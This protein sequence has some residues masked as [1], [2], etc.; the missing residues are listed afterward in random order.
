MRQ[1]RKRVGLVHKLR[2]RRRAEEVADGRNDGPDVDERLRR[3]RLD[4]LRGH[5]L[6]DDFVHARKADAELVEQQ[7]ADR[8]QAAVA[9]VVDVVGLADAVREREQIVDR[10]EDVIHRDVLGNQLVAARS[11]RAAQRV[12]VLRAGGGDHLEQH[13]KLDAFTQPQL[14]VGVGQQL[15]GV[16]HFVG[17]H[18]HLLLG[19]VLLVDGIDVNRPDAGVF[20]RLRVLARQKLPLGEQHLARHGRDGRARERIAGNAAAERELL[21]EFIASDG[22]DVVSLGVKEQIVDERD[23]AVDD[24][25]LAGTQLFIDFLERFLVGVGAVLLG[26]LLHQVLLER[27]RQHRLLA[28]QVGNLLVGRQP[29][30]AQQHRDG[31]LAV[32]VDADVEH[33]GRVGLVLQ[34]CAAVGDDGGGEQALA[35][36]V[37][38]R[39]IINAGR[40]HDLRDNDALSAVDDEGAA[41]GHHGEIA[42]VDF[43]LLQFARDLVVQPHKHLEGRGIVDVP[44]LAFLH[45]VLGRVAQGVID[46][47]DDKVAAVIGHRRDV[48]QHG[49]DV[50]RYE[51]LEGFLLHFNQV[52]HFQHFVVFRKRH[53][54]R[55]S[56]QPGFDHINQSDH[57]YLYFCKYSV[58]LYTSAKYFIHLRFF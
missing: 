22:R 28:E 38:S 53:S 54:G 23:G 47:V 36:L 29:E 55:F 50:L 14:L 45:A 31:Q 56:Q 37:L 24:R 49:L 15:G 42:H 6:L 44:L 1:L 25:R 20:K 51:I 7:L 21:I 18:A 9:E 4:V 30:R 13:V 11:Q 33:V 32:L 19:P 16:D 8:A 34:P 35:A 46:K 2:Q 58:K 57:S 27:G 39:F 48:L 3:D 40:T 26:L 10:G 52:G 5:F 41:V 17:E 12:L 43:L